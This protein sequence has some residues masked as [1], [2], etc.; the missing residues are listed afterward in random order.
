MRLGGG[1]HWGGAG[2]VVRR[3]KPGWCL[4]FPC[5]G[6]P[7]LKKQSLGRFVVCCFR[8]YFLIGP[9]PQ[10]RSGVGSA[11]S[12]VRLHKRS[13][14]NRLI[15]MRVRIPVAAVPAR[16]VGSR[17]CGTA[18]LSVGVAT[19][20]FQLTCC[21]EPVMDSVAD[22]GK[23][24]CI[25]AFAKLLALFLPPPPLLFILLF[26]FLFF[27]RFP[28]LLAVA[29]AIDRMKIALTRLAQ[30]G[31]LGHPLALVSAGSASGYALHS[32]AW[33]CTVLV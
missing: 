33:P 17:S 8:G 7:H 4:S 30:L 11:F 20:I 14:A 5:L 25:M 2:W 16:G 28:L 31:T 12:L 32:T 9:S 21:E 3:Q 13:L 26:C 29:N 6:R 27:S 15:R 22:D 1:R 24:S 19:R 23:C 10:L 18:F